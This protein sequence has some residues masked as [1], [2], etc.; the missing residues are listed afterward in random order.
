MHHLRDLRPVDPRTAARHLR[1]ALLSRNIALTGEDCLDL[2]ARQF[3]WTDRTELESRMAAAA[4]APAPLQVPRGWSASGFNLGAYAAGL[5]A[6][7]THLGRPV[8]RLSNPT[9]EN[10]HVSLSQVLAAAVYRGRRVR[11]AGWLRSGDVDG[12]ATI[13]LGSSDRNRN[14]LTF[15]NLEHLARDGAL[16]GTVDW[17]HRAI[18]MGIPEEAETVNIGFSLV[19]GG[20]AWFSGLALD[21]VG[22]E[23]PVTTSQEK[24]APDNLD[25][26]AGTLDGVA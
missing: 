20:T 8:F 14:Y 13:F 22:P 2:V 23:V 12:V 3:G 19:R 11:F 21:I 5:D 4:C 15:N 10:G 1:L 18:V 24:E 16:R 9:R 26:T 25:F 7:E 6:G 17:S